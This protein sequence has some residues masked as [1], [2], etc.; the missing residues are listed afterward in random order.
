MPSR[1]RRILTC[2]ES[3]CYYPVMPL[4]Q[5]KAVRDDGA[6]LRSTAPAADAD[7]LR[8]ELEDKGYLVLSIRKKG[9]GGLRG[10]VT[11]QD[12][13]LFTQEFATLV[14]AGLPILP[15]LDILRR[16]TEKPA[17][18]IVLD[19]IAED[20]TGGMALSD[21][22]ARHPLVFPPLF[23]ATVRAGEKS[24]A[25]VDV[26][27]RFIEYQKRMLAVRKK[28]VASLVYPVFLVLALC[29]VLAIFTF[30]VIPNFALM[31]GDQRTALPWITAALIAL[32]T[33]LSRYAP[34]VFAGLAAA[35]A[36]AI[37]WGRSPKG[38]AALDGLKL[39]IPL[40][41]SVL[42]QY[43]L[44]QITR[45]LATVLRGGIPLVQA[46][47]VTAGVIDNSVMTRRLAA[48]RGLVTE[49]TGLA[50]AIE[51]AALAPDILVRMVEVGEQS[52]DLPQVLDDVADFYDQEVEN[53]LAAITTLIEPVLMLAMGIII[54]VIVVALYL[55]IFQMGAHIQ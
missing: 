13:L 12:L 43:L 31:Y 46:I 47:D 17:F 32:T 20:I 40:V 34:F 19:R 23:A 10:A 21:A 1:L 45:T 9:G 36:G 50:A 44:A 14:K 26:L 2:G 38:R 27:R 16:R 28:L 11:P 39:R 8:R 18:R 30:Y 5:Y 41:R 24:G 25:L 54:A 4:F 33:A 48:V 6:T 52:G 42:A 15:S 7:E 22:L 3:I 37:V 49:G 35:I 53:R 55:P 51:R 29:A